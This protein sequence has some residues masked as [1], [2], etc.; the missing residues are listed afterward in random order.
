MIPQPTRDPYN[1]AL[2][3]LRRFADEGRFEPGG[4]LVVTEL[5]AEVGLSATPV[6]EALACLAGEGL[7]DRKRGRGYFYP[8]LS[9]TEIVDLYE[10]QRAYLHAALTLHYGGAQALQRAA[11]RSADGAA[12]DAFYEA[13]LDQ[14]GNTALA[15]AHGRVSARLA[16]AV[17]IESEI[18]EAA[19]LLDDMVSAAAEARLQ[20]LQALISVH[21]D[22]RCALARHIAATLQSGGPTARTLEA[23]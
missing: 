9:A 2:G 18:A 4:A 17:R 15:A 7:I 23:R 3:A 20:D 5:A 8:L 21:H 11:A 14:T 6:R 13:L 16:A 22:R 19:A 10:L 1:V 12:I